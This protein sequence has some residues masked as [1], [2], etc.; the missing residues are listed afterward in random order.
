MDELDMEISTHEIFE[1]MK[2]NSLN[3][4][5]NYINLPINKEYQN[6]RNSIFDI[7]YKITIQLG[8]KYQTF[9]LSTYYLDLIVTKRKMKKNNIY[10][11]GL[12]C[13]C[14]SAKFCENDPVVPHFKYFIRAYNKIVDYKNITSTSIL[15]NDEVSVCKLLKYKLNYFTIFDYNI[16]FFSN[17]LL[18]NEQ[19]IQIINNKSFN[20]S[21]K[22]NDINFISNK[23]KN[24]L[25]KIYIK[26]RN[27]LEVIIKNY[28]ICIKY[29]PL[30]I[31]L[32]IMKKSVEEVLDN[33]INIEKYFKERMNEYYKIDYESI[34]QY[35]QL[36]NEPEIQKIFN[37][38]EKEKN[39][40]NKT[41]SIR[42]R[43]SSLSKEKSII[44]NSIENKSIFSNSH[45]NGFY[46]RLISKDI[47]NNIN[48]GS[49]STF[50]NENINIL[51]KKD[52]EIRRVRIPKFKKDI[53][54]LN[55]NQ[56]N[57]NLL[58]NFQ[59]SDRNIIHR[60]NA[61]IRSETNSINRHITF[62]NLKFNSNKKSKNLKNNNLDNQFNVNP[63]KTAKINIK[64]NKNNK[65]EKE[66][67]YGKN[68][69][70]N[71]LNE[72][73][74]KS[75][76]YIE[77]NNL[78]DNKDN[79][80]SIQSNKKTYIKKQIKNVVIDSNLSKKYLIKAATSSNFYSKK[81]NAQ[82]TD[83]QSDSNKNSTNI[84]NNL[85]RINAFN[86]Q[87]KINKNNQANIG[88]YISDNID[89]ELY[90]NNFN[91]IN[92]DKNKIKINLLKNKNILENNLYTNNISKKNNIMNN[93]YHEKNKEKDYQ[94][95]INKDNGPIVDDHVKKIYVNVA[96][97]SEVRNNKN[98]NKQKENKE[99]ILN[100]KIIGLNFRNKI[101]KEKNNSFA[102]DN[103]IKKN[104]LNN[105]NQLNKINKYQNNISTKK[106]RVN[107]NLKDDI[108]LIN[109]RKI[110]NR[111][112][113][114]FNNRNIFINNNNINSINKNYLYKN[115]N[116]NNKRIFCNILDIRVN[117][118]SKN[119]SESTSIHQI[120]KGGSNNNSK[121]K[122][123]IFQ[124]ENNDK[125]SIKK[126]IQIN[127]NNNNHN[128][129]SKKIINKNNLNIIITNTLNINNINIG[130]KNNIPK[131]N[132]SNIPLNSCQNYLENESSTSRKFNKIGNS[133]TSRSDNSNMIFNNLFN[134]FPNNIK[135]NNKK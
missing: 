100:S 40:I 119:I 107:K 14:V 72:N 102:V 5:D 104:F 44:L 50:K 90:N 25:D 99:N 131:L 113:A 127:N 63:M 65:S 115:N 13:L 109:I 120:I 55:N 6:L 135:I 8:F 84:Y 112:P 54:I 60:K 16:F 106:F 58:K 30:F 2:N 62:N 118:Q 75:F 33:E 74:N 56:N 110:S 20:N 27:Y 114:S 47:S 123:Q 82:K 122:K 18:K 24:V 117:D 49:C 92:E 94:N 9:F 81:S 71:C 105:H 87:S 53:S 98:N 43:N 77:Q 93:S 134:K 124:K 59:N 126:N 38:K 11:L 83:I 36:L 7:L 29:N 34:Q 26:S 17:G 133:N 45:S 61:S 31:S 96:K 1:K 86:N 111:T 70:N 79:Y 69:K 116:I 91:I 132:I 73:T 15:R 129:Q 57:N 78:N 51:E 10:K 101:K 66:N 21:D 64:I 39:H 80:S 12:A 32:L 28:E 125:K 4:F 19:L 128:N 121:E 95:K 76:I 68:T 42:S 88:L 41:L 67:S 37:E 103:K 97:T 22:G 130:K 23:V 52:F 48:Q 46:K 89:N 35:Q 3:N 85:D 108:N